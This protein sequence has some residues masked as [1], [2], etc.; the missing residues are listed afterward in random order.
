MTGWILE[1]IIVDGYEEVER[2]RMLRDDFI[3]LLLSFIRCKN[4]NIKMQKTSKAKTL[5]GVR[6]AFIFLCLRVYKRYNVQCRSKKLI[7]RNLLLI[8][9][10]PCIYMY[11]Y[12]YHGLLFEL[13]K[14]GTKV[15]IA[16]SSFIHDIYKQFK[17]ISTRIQPFSKKLQHF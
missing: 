4:Q 5:N 6:N 11:K 7:V 9:L 1:L 10:S 17:K 12:E 13:K 3:I 8:S 14:F 2:C 16:T 15:Y